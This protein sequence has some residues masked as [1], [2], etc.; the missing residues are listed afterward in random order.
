MPLVQLSN[1]SII[2]ASPTAQNPVEVPVVHVSDPKYNG[3]TVDTRWTPE[4]ALLTH[5]AGAAWTVQYFSQV[6]NTD[7]GLGG[8]RPTSAPVH[9]QYRKIEQLIIRVADALTLS[10]NPETKVMTY[11][12]RGLV[13]S[14]IPNEGDMFTA[15]IGDGSMAI[16][17]V[18]SS[19][20]KAI[21]K[22]AAY[23]IAYEVST[24]DVHYVEDLESKVVETLVWREELVP[25]GESPVI[26]KSR[27]ELLAQAANINKII[28][29]Q[30]FDRFFSTEYSTLIVPGQNLAL[31][32]P[33]LATFMTQML[34]SDD[35]IEMI[36]MKLLNV[37]DDP[38]YL[39]NNLWKALAYQD[40]LHLESG[41]QRMGI[42]ETFKFEPNPFFSGIR[43]TG[44]P[45]VV[46]PKDPTPGIQ[47]VVSEQVKSQSTF[48]LA[49]SVGG[50]LTMFEDSNT[51]ALPTNVDAP[52]LYRVTFDDYYVLSQNFYDKTVAQSTL[53]VM[54]RQHLK[55]EAIDLVALMNTAKAVNKWGL[56]EQFYYTPI[57][58]ALIRGG[59]FAS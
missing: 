5:L 47:G 13:H 55:R 3:I 54:V 39:Q 52:N 10:Q 8:H 15:T 6:I 25:Y 7:S 24:D 41:F 29:R 50:E 32:D 27:D 16:F 40:E 19:E 26:L 58:L 28:L 48:A 12:G 53:E 46:Y 22:Q 44:I 1:S 56:V 20:K 9:Q 36:R 38:V 4:S 42:T 31:Y 35:C 14:F 49:A 2:V 33:Y 57:V 21:F 34:S 51:G 37:K 45:W 30:Y 18:L 17:R 43:F 59:K 23:E 11:S